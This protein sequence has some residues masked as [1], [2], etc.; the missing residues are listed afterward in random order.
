MSNIVENIRKGDI[1][2]N[3]QDLFFSILIKGLLLKLDD[4]IT[5]RK[6][7]IP[8]FILH[9]GDDT[10]Y[11]NAKGYNYSLEPSQVSNENYIYNIIPRCLVDLNGINLLSDQLSSPYTFGHLQ[12]E[13]ED[14][15]YSL[16][17]EFR[18]MP[19]KLTCDLKY[20]VDSFSDMLTLIQQIVSKLTFVQVYD[21]T[22]MGQDIKCSYKIPEDFNSEKLMDIDGAT[23]DNKS[24]TLSLS[25]EIETTFPIWDNKTI[26]NNDNIITKTNNNILIQNEVD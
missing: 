13:T 20:Y 18:R 2:I 4:K 17:G 10:M 19:I 3:N 23:T 22:Y 14:K 26:V 24:K 11:L 7:E 15:L 21:I 25:L 12:Y 9:T 1:D 8:H 16:C 6:K 5:I